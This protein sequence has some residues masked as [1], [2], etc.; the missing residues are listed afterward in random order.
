M[1]NLAVQ[2]DGVEYQVEVRYSLTS[3]DELVAVV[4]GE[5]IPVFLPG[6]NDLDQL[7]W[8]VVGDRPY[9]LVMDRDLHWLQ[10]NDGRHTIEVRDLEA[11]V[12]RPISG[13]G[14]VKAPIP[15][16]ITR[17]MIEPNQQVETGDPL[18]VLEAMKMENVIYAPRSGTIQRLNVQ[19]GQTV[20][21]DERLVEIE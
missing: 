19:P 12:T 8:M 16:L 9:E 3:P 17:I 10:A 14:R 5:E 21:L 4:D 11:T 1:T 15:G 6:S 20:V 18:L 7:E 13:D 2:I